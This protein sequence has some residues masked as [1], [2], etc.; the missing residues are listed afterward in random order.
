MTEGQ[1]HE[2]Y[3]WGSPAIA[4]AFLIAEGFT[5]AGWGLR[6]AISGE[7]AGLPIHVYD[8]DGEARI[9]PCGEILLTERSGTRI[10]ERGIMPLW[11]VQGSDTI[12]L[13]P[14]G[15]L[16]STVPGLQ[17]PWQGA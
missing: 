10:S 9:K 16:S 6:Q 15:S 3:L 13:N 4:A 5:A 12:H 17:G 14:L 11:S 7:I 2:A 8:D 1:G